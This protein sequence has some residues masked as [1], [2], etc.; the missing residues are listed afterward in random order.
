MWF[1]IFLVGM[2]LMVPFH[3]ISVRHIALRDRFGKETGE[4]IGNALGMLS[5]WGFFGF[6]FGIWLAPQP[7]F[8]L[9]IGLEPII[10]TVF[11]LQLILHHLILGIVFV[12]PGAYLGIAG[13]R[14]MGIEVAETHHPTEVVST[15][16]YSRVRHP[17][18]IGGILAHIGIVLIFQAESALYATIPII[19]VNI[20]LCMIE[21]REMVREFGSAYQEYKDEVPMLLPRIRT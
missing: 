9:D 14:E 13:V 19:L 16:I 18:Y 4:K 20:L 15:G 11:G 8:Y 5:G 12:I 21:E 17:Q 7:R 1:E 2:V 10:I 3:Y 6:W